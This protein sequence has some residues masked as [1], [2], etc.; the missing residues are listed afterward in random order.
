M[1][2]IMDNAEITPVCTT[3]AV[4]SIAITIFGNFFQ[5]G[6]INFLKKIYLIFVDR[7]SDDFI[8]FI[9][10][11]NDIQ[12]FFLKE[13]PFF[14]LVYLKVTH[15]TTVISVVA[16]CSCPLATIFRNSP[17]KLVFFFISRPKNKPDYSLINLS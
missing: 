17:S 4:I 7:I 15:K 9:T 16:S 2:V 13:S 6:G 1:N 11:H 12:C 14:Y 8:Y 10:L 5:G 3:T